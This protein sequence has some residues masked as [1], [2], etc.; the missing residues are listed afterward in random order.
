[1]GQIP[2]VLAKLG[3]GLGLYISQEIVE[4]HDGTIFGERV[5]GRKIVRVKLSAQVP[6]NS[7]IG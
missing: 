1:M 3:N 6:T 7:F 5:R 4:R 2:Q